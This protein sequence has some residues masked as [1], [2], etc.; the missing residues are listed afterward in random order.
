MAGFDEIVGESAQGE[1]PSKFLSVSGFVIGETTLSEIAEKTQGFVY[2][3]PTQSGRISYICAKSWKGGTEIFFESGAM[4]GWSILTSI[5]FT[6]PGY[7][8]DRKCHETKEA[9]SGSLNG[10]KINSESS[11][12]IEIIG[13]SPTYQTKSRLEITMESPVVIVVDGIEQRGAKNSGFIG[14]ISNSTIKAFSIYSIE[15]F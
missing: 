13:H 8:R 12:V 5:T 2:S 14:I 7:F 1:F 15:S 10:L 11:N 9:L 6:P 3:A 4:G